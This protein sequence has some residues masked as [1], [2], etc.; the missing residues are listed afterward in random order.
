[1]V[2]KPDVDDKGMEIREDR[3]GGAIDQGC[4]DGPTQATQL[5]GILCFNPVRARV[6]WIII[7]KQFD[8][9]SLQFWQSHLDKW[10]DYH[11]GTVEYKYLVK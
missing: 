3:R 4:P 9:V 5:E 7:L 8:N 2:S 11:A 1:M 10:Y 6:L